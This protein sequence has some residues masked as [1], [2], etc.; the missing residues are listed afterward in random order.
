[1]ARL[2]VRPFSAEFVEAAGGLLAAR[3]RAHRAVEPLLP[4]AYEEPATAAAEVEALTAAGATGAVGLRAG[5]VTGFLLGSHRDDELWGPNVWVEPA[6]HALDAAEDVRDLYATAARAWVDEGRVRHYS[7][8]PASDAGLVDA[9][10]RLSFGLQHELALREVPGTAWPEGVRLAQSEDVEALVELAPAVSNHHA[11]APVF[12]PGGPVTPPDE[13][14]ADLLDELPDESIGNLVAERDGAVAGWFHVVSVER[15]SVHSGL[16][17]PPGAAL[18]AWAATSPH[19]RGSGA[20]RSLTDAV[21][22]WAKQRGHE[23][24]VTD[25]RATNLLASR[26]W[27]RRGFR[28]TFLRLYRHIP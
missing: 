18:L 7:I 17:R 19:V 5:R 21:F 28:T 24:L 1:M 12:S 16:A 22:A 6:G 9:W 14:R 2:E 3:H 11:G 15:S 23:S 10:F 8:V 25:W 13:I 4:A 26:F 27:P 20:G